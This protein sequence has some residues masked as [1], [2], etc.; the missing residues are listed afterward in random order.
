MVNKLIAR[1]SDR[2]L[3]RWI[4]LLYDATVVYGMYIMANLIRHNFEY[5]SINPYVMESQSFLVMIIYVSAFFIGKSYTGI[6]RQTGTT[7]AVRVFSTTGAAFL[8]LLVLH[9]SLLPYEWARRILPPLSVLVIH[10]LLTPFFL[11]GSRFVIKSM[12]NNILNRERKKRVRVLIYGA[13]AA[14]MLTRNALMQ[15][16]YY[17]YEIIAFIDDNNSKVNKTLEGIP[18]LSRER[19]LN[20]NY[21][22]RYQVSQ[23]IIAIQKLDPNHR[24]EV[25]ETGLEIGLQVKVLPGI[26]K[27]ING[28]LSSSQL[29]QVHIEELLERDPIR[30]DNNQISYDIQNKVI[31]VTGAAGSIGSEIVRQLLQ[32]K[33]AR[34]IL[35]DQAESPL[36]DLQFEIKT[37]EKLRHVFEKALFIVA[38]VKDN[39]RMEHIF[40]TYKPQIV[41][42]AAAYKHVPLMEE[43]PYEAVL[44]NV[45]GTKTVADL[46]VKYNA[47]K[48]V[49]VSTDKAVNPTNVM[50][51]TKRIAEIYTQCIGNGHTQ[52]IT[53]RFGN[54]L[55]SNGSVIPIFKKQ[56]EKGGPVTL[57]HKEIIRYFMTIPEA[58]NLV[59]EAGAMGQGGEIFVF[60]MGKPVRIF[61]L[62]RKMIQLSGF[63]P[64]KDIKI[65]ETG[66]RPGE[67]LF[68]ELLTNNENTLH[69]HH[70]KIMRARVESFNRKNIDQA[71]NNLGTALIEKDIFLLVSKM[72]EMVPEYISNNSVFT[73]LDVKGK[74]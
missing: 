55:G 6:I 36:Y 30:L 34:V 49:M 54:V 69:T 1:Y 48:F 5:I 33:P 2:F 62:A 50:G 35:V 45:F 8:I 23:L 29:R 57:T 26:D 39:F 47:Q 24:R 4:V 66:L 73:S 61:D 10:F 40:A 52:F 72:K 32:Y 68:E 27:W 70:P 31:L 9:F 28:Q 13:G 16:M 74:G 42:H 67:K 7:D 44:V 37:D 59:L 18:V 53:T 14:G 17:Q 11:I 22:R 65:I 43:N 12:Y 51:A 3:S 38:N 20:I 60:D 58:C 64:E 21:T 41:Y 63:I 19:A 56:I 25:V 46:A 15:D 71:L